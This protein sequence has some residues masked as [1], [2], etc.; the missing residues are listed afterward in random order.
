VADL[1]AFVFEVTG[2]GIEVRQLRSAPRGEAVLL[3]FAYGP[4]AKTHLADWRPDQRGGFMA[5]NRE[6]RVNFG[7]NGLRTKLRRR[8]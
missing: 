7:R 2:K 8:R 1:T 4:T 5:R 6:V 3:A